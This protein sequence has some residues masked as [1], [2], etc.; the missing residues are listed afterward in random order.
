MALFK[1]NDL[2]YP[3]SGCVGLHIE[4][5]WFNLK[6]KGAHKEEYIH[7]PTEEEVDKLIE[8]SKGIISMITLA[9]EVVKK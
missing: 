2:R 4:G 1:I 5:P 8:M 6:K 9:P 3:E 7:S